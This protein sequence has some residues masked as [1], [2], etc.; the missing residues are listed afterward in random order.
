MH[1][2]VEAVHARKG[3]VF[4]LLFQWKRSLSLK[5]LILICGSFSTRTQTYFTVMK[6]NN[7]EK[8]Q[9]IK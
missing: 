8:V 7:N 5:V 2:K 6:I 9:E 1:F 3:A 4:L